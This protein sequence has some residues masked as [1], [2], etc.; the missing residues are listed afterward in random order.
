MQIRRTCRQMLTKVLHTYGD[1]FWFVIIIF[2]IVFSF[3]FCR[4]LRFDDM[5]AVR[6][7]RSFG[8]LQTDN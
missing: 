8:N 7:L 4:T 2:A 1:V 5:D 3:S 6:V